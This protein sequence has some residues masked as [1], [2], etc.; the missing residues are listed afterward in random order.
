MTKNIVFHQN[1]IKT[2]ASIQAFLQQYQSSIINC[3]K[4]DEDI[5]FENKAEN[6]LIHMSSHESKRYTISTYKWQERVGELMFVLSLTNTNSL[7][8]FHRVAS[9]QSPVRGRQMYHIFERILR[10]LKK[11]E[12]VA[13]TTVGCNTNQRSVVNR[14][15]KKL[16]RVLDPNRAVNIEYLEHPERFDTVTIADPDD[17]F[18]HANDFLVYKEH[19]EEIEQIL[20][21]PDEDFTKAIKR[22]RMIFKF[23]E[24]RLHKEIV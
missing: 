14:C 22:Q 11:E 12:V 17:G 8:L 13:Y 20:S 4:I 15:Q 21:I 3:L 1:D 7:D 18:Y 2:P 23:P 6:T 24:I 10:E 5:V 9:P 19:K 16:W